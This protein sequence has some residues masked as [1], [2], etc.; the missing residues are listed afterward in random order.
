MRFI[1]VPFVVFEPEP[2]AI[3]DSSELVEDDG[4]EELAGSA[5][6]GLQQTGRP[7]VQVVDACARVLIQPLQ[8]LYDLQHMVVLY[9]NE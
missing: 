3:S 2:V 8:V 5:G 1:P 4:P 7:D 6:R 9:I